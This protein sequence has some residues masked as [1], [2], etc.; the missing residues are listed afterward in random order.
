MKSK[1]VFG[2]ASMHSLKYIIITGVLLIVIQFGFVLTLEQSSLNNLVNHPL[3]KYSFF[4]YFM[5]AIMICSV[6]TKASLSKITLNRLGI[7]KKRMFLDFTINTVISIIVVWTI[8][9][10]S[11]MLISMYFTKIAS[12]EIVSIQTIYL[13]NF[14]SDFFHMIIPL[15]DSFHLFNNVVFILMISLLTSNYILSVSKGT[16][17]VIAYGST[18]FYISS[19]GA[20]VFIGIIFLLFTI[21]E[22][23][24]GA[25]LD[26][27]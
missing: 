12:S 14:R 25:N 13:T 5:F 11:L 18:I 20:T 9:I 27:E 8:Q 24:K 19:N 6:L 15:K 4:V 3:L 7:T 1:N 2:L 21:Y 10:L 16:N 17:L 23:F 22:L 26:E